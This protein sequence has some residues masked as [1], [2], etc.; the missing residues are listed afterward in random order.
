MVVYAVAEPY[1]LE[2]GFEGFEV[3]GVARSV[4]G[5]VHGL[6][7][8]AD[9]EVGGVVLVPE[10]VAAPEGCLGEIVHQDFLVEGQV[11]EF[12]NFV[13]EYFDV[14]EVVDHIIEVVGLL[15]RL[16]PVAGCGNEAHCNCADS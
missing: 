1:L 11:L 15:C 2:V 10:D 5:C 6:E 14:G 7:H 12:G 8:A 3:V 13:A 16:L 4:V 9:V